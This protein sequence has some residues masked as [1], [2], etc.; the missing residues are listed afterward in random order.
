MIVTV[1]FFS[2]VTCLC[3]AHLSCAVRDQVKPLR[4]YTVERSRSSKHAS[5]NDSSTAYGEDGGLE[6]TQLCV[7]STSVF[8]DSSQ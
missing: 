3:L 4:G 6:G 2:D 7:S 5:R 1:R 8:M